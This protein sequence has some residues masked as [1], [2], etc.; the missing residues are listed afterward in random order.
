MAEESWKDV[1]ACS[2]YVETTFWSDVLQKQVL[3]PVP[4]Q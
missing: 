2:F 3:G 1:P 4:S